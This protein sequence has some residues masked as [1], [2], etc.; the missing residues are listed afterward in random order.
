MP[1]SV[2]TLALA[3]TLLLPLAALHTAAAADASGHWKG[4]IQIPSGEVLV[5][6]D[7]AL[8]ASGKLVGTFSNP[9]DQIKGYPLASVKIDGSSVRFE[10][11]TVGSAPQTFDGTLAADGR[12]L[13][14]DFLLD[15]Y[16]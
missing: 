1:I 3:T 11:R 6:V 7:L 5:E 10:I 15:V 14:G 2:R 8:D 9:G 13:A 16:S 12:S 4:A